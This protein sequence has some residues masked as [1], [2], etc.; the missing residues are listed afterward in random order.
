MK[1]KILIVSAFLLLSFTQDFNPQ[2]KEITKKFFPEMNIDIQTPAFKKE[3]GYT[4]YD[5]LIAF[6]NQL[7]K[8]KPDILSLSF[9]GESQKGKAI[10]MILLNKASKET[11]LK[12]WIQGG[13]HGDEMA[14]TEG[15][16]FI[17]DKLLH[18]PNYSYLLDRLEIAIVPMANIDG[19]EAQ[20]RYAANGLDLNR[21]QTKL[22][23]K[24]SAFLK[25]SFSDFNAEVALDFHEYRPYRKEYSQYGT[26]G[27]TFRYDAMFMS[28]GNL[29]VPEKLRNYTNETFVKN[30][31]IEL[32]E[33]GLAFREY[34]TADKVLGEVHFNQGSM[35]ARSSATSYALANTISSLIEVRGVGIGRTSFKRR[36]FTTFCVGMSYLKTAYNQVNEVKEVLKFEENS[37][38]MA[39]VTSKK[40]LSK[41]PLIV[42]DLETNNEMTLEVKVENASR[43]IAKLTRKRPI[44]YLIDSS[45]IEILK[46]LHILGIKTRV[47]EKNTTIEVETYSVKD[48]ETDKQKD[49]G[50]FKQKVLTE[51]ITKQVNFL[52]GTRI[53][54]MNQENSNLAIEV[55]EPEAPNSFV[56]FGVLK[57][58]P[59]TL[60]P[61]YRYLKNEKLY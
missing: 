1:Q 29:N 52:K 43:A 19:Y 46:K 58:S 22:I 7:Q 59:N 3:K 31:G 27:I 28:S 57:A 56:S 26:M 11:K 13:L 41:Q 17:L 18:D 10:P 34:L 44:A 37:S 21:D 2:S 12:V 42:I 61:I 54:Y 6:I 16:L 33:N 32:Q 9:I 38:A 25:Q 53:V 45:E 20:D 51:I 48:V 39:V 24:E 15:V 23:I 8:D 40:E 35:S 47:L 4:N 14:S 60:L 49:E 50:V 36:V 5:E 30:A 55:L